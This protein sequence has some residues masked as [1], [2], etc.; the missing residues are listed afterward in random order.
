MIGVLNTA[1]YSTLGGTATNAG[2]AVYYLAAPDSQALPFVVWDYVSDSDENLDANRTK[3]ELVFI[4]A[5]A[6]TPGAAAAIDAQIDALLHLQ[7]L[8]VTGYVNYWLARESG[9]SLAETDQSG[10]RSYMAGAEY[11][12]KLDKS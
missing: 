5:Y 10:R 6:S 2:T 3:D 1:L 8:T 12:I 4:R 9:Y 11:R 7:T